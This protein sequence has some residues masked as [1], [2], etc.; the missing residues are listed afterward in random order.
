MNVLQG[1]YNIFPYK[2]VIIINKIITAWE[3][4]KPTEWRLIEIYVAQWIC[5]D[6]QSKKDIPDNTCSTAKFVTY[7]DTFW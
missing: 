3:K 4:R 7:A 1:A 6:T 2:T 5:Y